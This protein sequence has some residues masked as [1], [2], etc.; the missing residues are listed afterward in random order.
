M[1]LKAALHAP[2]APAWARF[3]ASDCVLQVKFMYRKALRLFCVSQPLRSH[4]EM[5]FSEPFS[6]HSSLLSG[7]EPKVKEISSWR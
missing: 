4:Q 5:C 2:P 6:N 3:Q 1:P 7:D